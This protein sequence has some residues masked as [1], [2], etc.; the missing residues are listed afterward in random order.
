NIVTREFTDTQKGGVSATTDFT[1]GIPGYH[2]DGYYSNRFGSSQIVAFASADYSKGAP[3]YLNYQP[4]STDQNR[5][6]QVV[7]EGFKYA[8]SP[9]DRTRLSGTVIHTDGL[10]DDPAPTLDNHTVND[11]HED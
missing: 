8:W 9:S 10:L 2:G 6:Y 1:D 4:S 11:R 7:T 3:A 5:G